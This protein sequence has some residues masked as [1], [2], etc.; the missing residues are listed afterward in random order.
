M[1]SN[2]WFEGIWLVNMRGDTKT[3]TQ[4][5]LVLLD[6][7]NKKELWKSVI[8]I[9]T[10][11]LKISVLKLEKKKFKIFNKI[12]WGQLFSNKTHLYLWCSY[13][14]CDTF[15]KQMNHYFS[16]KKINKS[17]ISTGGSNNSSLPLVCYWTQQRKTW[18]SVLVIVHPCVIL[19]T[20]G[21]QDKIT[22][23]PVVD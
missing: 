21:C 2:V 12:I 19:L 4:P 6:H 9:K 3:A 17:K 16:V 7:L 10:L 13:S 14:F 22:E 15:N 23:W 5:I 11:N 20:S 18:S 8:R 1:Q